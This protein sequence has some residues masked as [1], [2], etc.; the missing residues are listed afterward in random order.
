MKSIDVA[1]V[2]RHR[3]TLRK[4]FKEPFYDRSP[5]RARAFAAAVCLVAAFICVTMVSKSSF[6]YVFHDG[7][8][9]NW[10]L[11]VGRGIVNGLVPYRDLFEQKGVLLYMLFALNY[12][13]C[14]NQ[15]YVIYVIQVLCGAA[16]L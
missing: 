6:L 5:A 11:T 16:F 14:G 13:I 2:R 8:D 9:V 15:L 12:A 7:N 10:F 4:N 3:G 1:A